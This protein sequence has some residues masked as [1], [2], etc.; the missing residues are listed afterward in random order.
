MTRGRDATDVAISTSF[1]P[2]TFRNFKVIA[3]EVM[4]V[5]PVRNGRIYSRIGAKRPGIS[6][7]PSCIK[8]KLSK[9]R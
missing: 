7:S 5:L 2:C 9:D 1:G 3:N 8:L 6:D 4:G